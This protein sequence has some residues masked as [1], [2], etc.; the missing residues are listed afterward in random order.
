MRTRDYDC[1]DTVLNKLEVERRTAIN[2]APRDNRFDYNCWG[3]TAFAKGWDDEL[4]WYSHRDMEEL[5]EC[6]TVET[7]EPTP[8]DIGVFRDSYN[9]L[10]HTAVL[11]EYDPDD[12]DKILFV[13]KPGDCE[14]ELISLTELYNCGSY[15]AYH[16][17]FE[18]RRKVV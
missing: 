12:E 6:D 7:T 2:Y 1:I 4:Y 15:N 16:K 10:T 18:F 14:I 11:Y 17:L 13:H 5:L 8:G 3:F 9:D